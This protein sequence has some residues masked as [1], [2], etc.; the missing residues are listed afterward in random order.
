MKKHDRHKNVNG[1]Y[2]QET[3]SSIPTYFLDTFIF[4]HAAAGHWSQ[5]WWCFL[6]STAGH[7]WPHLLQSGY[8]PTLADHISYKL[9]HPSLQK[10]QNKTTTTHTHIHK[11]THTRTHTHT[12]T[13]TQ[14]HTHTNTNTHTNTHTHTHIQIHKHHHHH[15]PKKKM[16][17]PDLWMPVKKRKFL[18]WSRQS[19]HEYK[20]EKNWMAVL[21]TAHVV[22]LVHPNCETS[23]KTTGS[24]PRWSKKM[25]HIKLS[26]WGK[27]HREKITEK[28]SAPKTV[29]SSR[30]FRHAFIV[31]IQPK[32]IHW[33]CMFLSGIPVLKAVKLDT[34]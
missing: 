12:Q 25:H 16:V 3:A 19:E 6:R 27:N 7:G 5:R 24:W 23:L 9:K 11:H 29:Q 20:M 1:L 28:K 30:R 22:K 14:T 8:E 10:K 34:L 32:I 26:S 18:C 31:R 21:S 15:P 17:H 4:Q 33:F 2:V 13:H